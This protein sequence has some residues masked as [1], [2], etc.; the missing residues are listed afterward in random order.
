MMEAAQ[1]TAA[2]L[3]D[4]VNYD[5]AMK[6]FLGRV[7]AYIY[8]RSDGPYPKVAPGSKLNTRAQIEQYWHGQTNFWKDGLA[9]ETCRDF[10]HLGSGIA[11][12]S[13][14]AET[15]RIQ[16]KDL[17]QGDVGNRLR[18]ALEFHSGHQIDTS[19]PPAWLCGSRLVKGLGPSE[20]K[21]F[22]STSLGGEI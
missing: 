10:S 11:S 4:R 5:K 18:H 8:P 7:P 15:S 19:D 13:H 17:Y 22:Y 21:I 6:K 9:Q 3:N 1:G 2:P 14:V 20:S 16:G 12:I